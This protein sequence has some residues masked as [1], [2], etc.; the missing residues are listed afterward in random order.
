MN[1]KGTYILL[2]SSKSVT[3]VELPT[4]WNKFNQYAGGKMNINCKSVR[5]NIKAEIVEAHWHTN[6]NEDWVV[7]LTGDNFLKYFSV[8][9][10]QVAFKVYNLNNAFN[11]NVEL[12]VSGNSRQDAIDLSKTEAVLSFDIGP[13]L[14][15]NEN[16]CFPIYLLKKNGRI[17]CILE[18]E[19]AKCKF[20]YLGNI[21]LLP[22]S[23]ETENIEILSFICLN[24]QPNCVVVLTSTGLI[25][26]C[27]F[28]PTKKDAKGENFN[29]TDLSE[30]ADMSESLNDACFFIYESIQLDEWEDKIHL[31]KDPSTPYRYFLYQKNG[32]Y[33][34]YLSWLEELNH[35]F[36]ND[37]SLD[38]NEY[39]TSINSDIRHLICT[40]PLKKASN[41]TINGLTIL[42]QFGNTNTMLIA[43]TS[44]LKFVCINIQ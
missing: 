5:F 15:Y 6:I 8:S 24:Q 29:S 28:M 2:V 36:S 16:L 34:I 31:I 35:N 42:H 33:S 25:Y 13:R 7:C 23:E 1:Q 19:T 20:E 22:Y 4:K 17:E 41:N 44:Q 43:L 37:T 38:I 39:N 27:I 40:N 9:T 26:N 14:Q 18:Y 10:A 32:V 21:S 11:N 12:N 3:S 30:E